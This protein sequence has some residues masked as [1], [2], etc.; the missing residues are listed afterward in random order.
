MPSCDD[1]RVSVPPADAIARVAAICEG[2]EGAV[3]HDAWT[4]VSWRVGGVTFAH[5]VEIVD[6]KP[7]IYAR[8]FGTDGQATVLTFQAD[9]EDRAALGQVGPPFHLPP[10]RKGIVGVVIDGDSDWDEIT[11]LVS[12]SHRICAAR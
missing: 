5:V 2:L 12:E 10:W 6:G 9:E 8:V 3:E 11:E 1:R 7:P 4:G